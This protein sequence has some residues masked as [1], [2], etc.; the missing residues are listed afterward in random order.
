MSDQPNEFRIVTPT[1]EHE[2]RRRALIEDAAF[3][4]ETEDGDELADSPCSIGDGIFRLAAKVAED[5]TNPLAATAVVRR[6]AVDAIAPPDEAK[7]LA[8]FTEGD[9][10]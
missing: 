2:L 10:G 9:A 3:A 1:V 6:S 5:R 8:A 4:Y 7:L